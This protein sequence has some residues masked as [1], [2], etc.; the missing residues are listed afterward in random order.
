MP[1][2][3]LTRC[4]GCGDCVTACP[5]GTLAIQADQAVLV[6]PE[7]CMYCMVCEDVCPVAAIDLPSQIVKKTQNPI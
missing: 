4:M 7:T 5:T 6:A 2:I 1:Q 3:N